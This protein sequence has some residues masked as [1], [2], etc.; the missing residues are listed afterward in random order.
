MK[1]E[2]IVGLLSLVALGLTYWGVNFLKGT[3]VISKEM[4][5]YAV[6]NKVD[7]LVEADKVIL[8]GY[9]VGVVREIKFHPDNSGK[10]IVKFS[11]EEGKFDFSSDTKA[12]LVSDIL[13]TKSIKLIPGTAE[14]PLHS[15]DTLRTSIETT[16]DEQ[17]TEE[18]RPLKIKVDGLLGQVDTLLIA[19]KTIL[20]K[21]A[22]TSINNSF[23]NIDKALA[24]F[25]KTSR[26]LDTLIR[27]ES[28]RFTQLSSNLVSITGN[29]REKNEELATTVENIAVITDSIAASDIVNTINNA[30]KAM[31]ELAQAI[32]RVNN[33]EGTVGQL[34]VND[35]LY[36]NLEKASKDLD[37]LMKDMRYNPA[38]Y[39]HFSIF[40][41]KN[42]HAPPIEE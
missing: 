15:G 7:G 10:L 26:R 13:G 3:N 25:E 23:A 1:K 16:I 41:R 29:I 40:G 4:I 42:K 37:L 28:V 30:N 20:N 2:I 12:I 18:L 34:M 9:Q 6:Y 17:I 27:R 22:T 19:I 33:G 36:M 32:E 39:V 14:E 11:I 38:R 5:V 21:N 31:D 35:T 8:S 24:T